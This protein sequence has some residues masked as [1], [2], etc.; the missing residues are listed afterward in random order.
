MIATSKSF[1]EQSTSSCRPE[2]TPFYLRKGTGQVPTRDLSW[3]NVTMLTTNYYKNASLSK[4]R[5]RQS[6]TDT[7]AGRGRLVNSYH[8]YKRARDELTALVAYTLY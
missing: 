1:S 3:W 8:A 4:L 6:A 5:R 7:L 2:T